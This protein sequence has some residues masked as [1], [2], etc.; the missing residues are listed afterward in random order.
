MSA[1]SLANSRTDAIAPVAQAAAP[2]GDG[3]APGLTSEV[4]AKAAVSDPHAN[5]QPKPKWKLDPRYIAPLFVTTVLIGAH[6]SAGILRNPLFTLTA[7][8]TSILLEFLLGRFVTGKTPH[9]A[10]AYVSGISVGILVRSVYWWVYAL[11]SAISITSKYVFRAKGRHIWNPSNFG[12]AMMVLLAADQMSTLSVQ[13]G[14]SIGPMIVIWCLGVFIISRLKRFHICATYVATFFL[15]GFV[16]AA[17][18]GHS[19]WAEISP[20]TG[21]MYQLFIFFMITDPKTTVTSKKGQILVAFAIGVM[22]MV[23]RLSNALLPADLQR[24]SIHAPYY[25]LFTVGPI[26]N[27]IEIYC[28]PPKK[29]VPPPTSAKPATA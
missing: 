18:T 21:P 17:I 7:I 11:T 28:F 8:G 26:A 27:L 25:A 19:Y 1:E 22:E 13:F 23:Y 24:L 12:I 3:V 5:T 15:L 14:S 2:T 9:M 29:T 20:I 4:G 16:R 6:L 10:S